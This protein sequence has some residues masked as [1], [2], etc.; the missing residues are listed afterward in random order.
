MQLGLQGFCQFTG[1]VVIATKPPDPAAGHFKNVKKVLSRRYNLIKGRKGVPIG[2]MQAVI[3]VFVW[4][5]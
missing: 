3:L 4:T 1:L 2:L 5:W